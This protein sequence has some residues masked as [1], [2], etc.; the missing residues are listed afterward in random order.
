M[1]EN[2]KIIRL[3]TVIDLP[4][5]K[6][7]PGESGAALNHL[8]VGLGGTGGKVIAA[9]RRAICE[10]VRPEDA[11]QLLLDYLYVDSSDE[12]VHAADI[13]NPIGAEDPRWRKLG[14]SVQLAP[15]QIVHLKQGNFN[16]IVL[17]PD[18]YPAYK[19]WMGSPSLWRSVIDNNPMGIRAG[20]Q[21]RRFGRYLFASN[22][23][24]VS[25]AL[26]DRFNARNQAGG[27]S[28]NW[29]VHVVAGLAGGTGSGSLIDFCGLLRSIRPGGQTKIIQYLVCP[30]RDLTT[31]AQDNYY[32]NGYAALL[33]LNAV[34]TGGFHPCNVVTT[35]GHYFSRPDE[36]PVDNTF[37][38]TNENNDLIVDMDSSI[39]QVIAETLFQTIIASGDANPGMQGGLVGAVAQ[40]DGA[41]QAN[42]QH[43]A[44]RDYITG[45]NYGEGYEQNP[46]DPEAGRTRANRF[47]TFGIK[48]AVIPREEVK[49]FASFSFLRQSLL[50][51]LNNNW[52]EGVGYQD[53]AQ[54]F[55]AAS[56]VRSDEAL[57]AWNLS[58]EKLLLEAKSLDN[59]DLA[60]RNLHDEFADP[61]RIKAESIMRE[62]K[63]KSQWIAP[64][65]T[66][67]GERYDRTFRKVGV[68]QFYDTQ[69]NQVASKRAAQ[70][71]SIIKDNLFLRWRTGQMSAATVREVLA[72]E[73]TFI[74]ERIAQFGKRSGEMGRF[75][76]TKEQDRKTSAASYAANGG[77]IM[78]SIRFDRVLALQAH[79]TIL[80][81]YH[82]ARARQHA[83][84]LVDRVLSL[85]LPYVEAMLA[86][87]GTLAARLADA[88]KTAEAE[89][90]SR[91]NNGERVQENGHISKLL[92]SRHVRS[93]VNRLELEQ[94]LQRAQA[95]ASRQALCEAMGPTA[96]FAT[97]AND[98]PTWRV[99]DILGRPSSERVEQ[100][101]NNLENQNDR[102][103]EGSIVQK[104][105]QLFG[106]DAGGLTR[107]LSG[108]ARQAGSFVRID[109]NAVARDV[110]GVRNVNGVQTTLVAF[111]PSAAGLGEELRLFRMKL[112]QA[113][114]AAGAEHIVTVSNRANELTF[115]SLTNRFALRHMQLLERLKEEYERLANGRNSAL[116]RLELH[117]EGEGTALYSIVDE[118]IDRVRQDALPYW[119]IADVE[120][121]LTERSNPATGRSEVVAVTTDAI[122]IQS[123]TVVGSSL[124]QGTAMLT[125]ATAR[126]LRDV[127]KR[128]IDGLIHV[129]TRKALTQKL[130]SRQNEAFQ[131]AQMNEADLAFQQIREMVTKAR[132]LLN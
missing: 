59:D 75:A 116:K 44:W 70:I 21:I 60:W 16:R 45:E 101:L 69:R 24:T 110:N 68:A 31:W 34:I 22:A 58:D 79:G 63:S 57:A 42:V 12:D 15:A 43:R 27:A 89:R 121:L 3:A 97:F 107:F 74:R 39:P 61:I 80:A 117:L 113:I 5:F 18:D 13:T 99:L 124:A 53:R 122:G 106:N 17:E 82:A 132:A 120:G 76:D 131:A 4:S 8:I 112:E 119:L 114:R 56:F 77:L 1:R 109:P 2:R 126:M 10:Q 83:Y 90:A 108:L 38:I 111:L 62:V 73:V 11:E 26:Q 98:V 6:V 37:I 40:G 33:E 30:E 81:E 28:A 55:D 52:L 123:A 118:P 84:A 96:S 66:F 92:D 36:R 50:Q 115:L 86:D 51:A 14:R 49:E 7:L 47:I 103:L 67:A 54:D 65:E 125:R 100:I 23:A 102:I 19:R 9:F 130:V 88:A 91:V 32:A 104:L 71:A 35:D 64:L 72:Q 41:G 95:D 105:Y 46:E 78:G 48:R 94:D 29:T 93:V 127:V 85:L 128:H 20:G 87:V 129:D 25:G